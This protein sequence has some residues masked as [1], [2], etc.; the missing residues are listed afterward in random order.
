MSTTNSKPEVCSVCNGTGAPGPNDQRCICGGA[1]TRDAE[2]DN[3][4]AL[5]DALRSTFQE[6]QVRL[7]MMGHNCSKPSRIL[8]AIEALHQRAI[9]A[10]EEFVKLKRQ[11]VN[12]G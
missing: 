6:V 9:D 3:L 1:G 5:A 8:P 7:T 10:E 11:R 12:R 4:R 2:V